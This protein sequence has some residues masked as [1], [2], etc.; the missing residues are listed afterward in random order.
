[1]LFISCACQI[2]LAPFAN[3]TSLE[4]THC[5][6][7][8]A[9]GVSPCVKICE[10]LPL[11]LRDFYATALTLPRPAG[12]ATTDPC[13]LRRRAAARATAGGLGQDPP[14]LGGAWRDDGPAAFAYTIDEAA[15]R[16]RISR[17]AA[18]A[19]VREG[20]PKIHRLD[21]S[22][23]ILPSDLAAFLAALPSLK[24]PPPA[25]QKTESRRDPNDR[26]QAVDRPG[27]APP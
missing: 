24:L 12:A 23:L 21:V 6:E 20:S 5:V 4:L 7:H 15:A 19:A 14:P 25:A 27:R 1:M 8:A 2:A 9:P 11:C 13:R 3:L 18:Y 22:S 26:G 16:A 10:R 17:I